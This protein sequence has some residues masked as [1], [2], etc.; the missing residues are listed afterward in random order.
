MLSSAFV[1]TAPIDQRVTAGVG[2]RPTPFPVARTMG[3][4]IRDA[5]LHL[6]DGD[7]AS[8]CEACTQ[9]EIER[10]P[11]AWAEVAAVA[12]CRACEVLGSSSARP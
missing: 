7:G 11:V 9:Q 3:G 10:L 5:L 4:G 2:S 8:L 1:P 6:V 12:R